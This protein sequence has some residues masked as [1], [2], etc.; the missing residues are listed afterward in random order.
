MTTN[1]ERVMRK[2][3]LASD[4]VWSRAVLEAR[5][6]CTCGQAID[7]DEVWRWDFSFKVGAC[8]VAFAAYRNEPEPMPK[9]LAEVDRTLEL[10]AIAEPAPRFVVKPASEMRE[11]EPTVCRATGQ[12]Y[13]DDYARRA[14]AGQL[15]EVYAHVFGTPYAHGRMPG[16]THWVIDTHSPEWKAFQAKQGK[17]KVTVNVPAGGWS[18]VTGVDPGFSEAYA[19]RAI[20]EGGEYSSPRTQAAKARTLTTAQENL[21][22]AI[23]K[24][25][26][27]TR[28]ATEAIKATTGAVCAYE[29]AKPSGPSDA[30]IVEAW[31]GALR[32]LEAIGDWTEI[33][34]VKQTGLSWCSS[35]SGG[36]ATWAEYQAARSRELNRRVT[37]SSEATKEAERRRV[38]GPIDDVDG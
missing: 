8:N 27:A 4:H 33:A 1:E 32:G 16:S 10:G 22:A 30:E 19:F 35:S 14:N 31:D 11:G 37:T 6:V 18:C 21:G 34:K 38:M 13:C 25:A 20:F 36:S 26:E 24:V 9:G 23:G 15:L 3:E 12:G 2:T 5:H 17:L 29:A 28:K 7:D